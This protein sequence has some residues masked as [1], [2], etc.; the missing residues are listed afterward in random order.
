MQKLRKLQKKKNKKDKSKERSAG[1]GA[2]E[3][4]TVPIPL[5]ELEERGAIFRANADF[6]GKGRRL[7]LLVLFS[8]SDTNKQEVEKNSLSSLNITFS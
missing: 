5:D 2:A 1:P 3:G 4:V 8:S 7:P 6:E